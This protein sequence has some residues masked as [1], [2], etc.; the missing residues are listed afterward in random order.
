[1]MLGKLSLL[2]G[3]P[4]FKV[5]CDIQVTNKKNEHVRSS[6]LYQRRFL[7]IE[8]TNISGANLHKDKL[9]SKLFKIKRYKI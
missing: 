3:A 8:I 9:W 5:A 4:Y 2:F 1:M 6:C 7:M